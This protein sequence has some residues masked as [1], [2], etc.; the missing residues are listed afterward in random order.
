MFKSS[1]I[2]PSLS[3]KELLV[4]ISYFDCLRISYF[5][6]N[7]I[8]IKILKLLLVL[9]KSAYNCS[10][11][12]TSRKTIIGYNHLWCFFSL[13][14]YDELRGKIY[15]IFCLYCLQL[16][17]YL[18]LFKKNTPKFEINDNFILFCRAL[19]KFF[20]MVAINTVLALFVFEK[21]L[22]INDNHNFLIIIEFSSIYI[23]FFS[24]NSKNFAE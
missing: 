14:R 10:Y 6:K 1:N 7:F 21:K 8:E 18:I 11:F 17:F 16:A 15:F 12:I 20:L 5:L 9:N 23:F 19:R 22:N 4:A 2:S 3:K 13:K 24:F